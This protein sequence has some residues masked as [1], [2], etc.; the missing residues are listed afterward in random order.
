MSTNFPSFTIVVL[1]KH[2]RKK[3]KKGSHM[4]C[5]SWDTE[6]SSFEVCASFADKTFV[7]KRP[8]TWTCLVKRHQTNHRSPG[9][10]GSPGTPIFASDFR[11]S[12]SSPGRNSENPI[13]RKANKFAVRS[14]KTSPKTGTFCFVNVEIG[15]FF[16]FDLLIFFKTLLLMCNALT[17]QVYD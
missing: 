14:Q 16:N 15:V 1:S 5:R 17:R 7:S 3:D 12:S 6:P 10:T 2:V 8:T 13:G 9:F 11:P 4:I